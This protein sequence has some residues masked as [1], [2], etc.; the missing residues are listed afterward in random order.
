MC[1]INN[2]ALRDF[3]SISIPIKWVNVIKLCLHIIRESDDVDPSKRIIGIQR[4][5]SITINL[6]N[7]YYGCDK[8]IYKHCMVEF[9]LLFVRRYMKS[10]HYTSH[11]KAIIIYLLFS[12]NFYCKI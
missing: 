10:K 4:V 7:I 11:L 2:I 8:T 9:L 5:L 1:I 6:F 3:A 12:N